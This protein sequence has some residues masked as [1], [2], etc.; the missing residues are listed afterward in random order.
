MFSN[1]KIYFS[2]IKSCY[3]QSTQGLNF[4]AL[5]GVISSFDDGV[6]N[7]DITISRLIRRKKITIEVSSYYH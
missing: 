2:S 6:P 3:F 5:V 7:L 1:L 4:D